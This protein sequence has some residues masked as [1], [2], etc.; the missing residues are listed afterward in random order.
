MKY[1]AVII[2]AWISVFTQAGQGAYTCKNAKIRLFSAAPI[3]DISASTS[4]GVSTYNAAT[5]ELEFSVNTN[6][7]QFPKKLMQEHFNT[8][9]IESEKYPKATFTGKLQE[10]PDLSKNGTSS[11]IVVGELEVHGVKLARTINGNMTVNNGVI[12]MTSEFMVKTADHHIKVPK[13]VFSKIEETI[14]M[15]V[16]AVYT[17][18]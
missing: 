5:G 6:S 12:S 13:I 15:N 14:K 18:Q 4:S 11:I 8:E 16:S 9:Y 3:A 2:L 17:K 10:H 1:I 7:F